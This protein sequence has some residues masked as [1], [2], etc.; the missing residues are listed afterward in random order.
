MKYQGDQNTGD[1]AR[2]V[3]Q[4]RFRGPY[5]DYGWE[6]G[7]SVLPEFRGQDVHLT[8]QERDRVI[9]WQRFQ[10][11][12]RDNWPGPYTGRG[13]R[14]YTRSDERIYEDVSELMT[15]HG[16]LDARN[17]EIEVQHGEVTLT[18]EVPDRRSKRLAED[19]ADTVPGVQDVHNRLKINEKNTPNR[20]VDRVGRSGV[21]PASEADKAPADSEAQ[22][23][24][25]WGQGERGAMG[26][27]DHGESEIHPE[28]L[29]QNK[30]KGSS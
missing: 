25:S 9:S 22:G 15:Y 7:Q 5:N 2:Q 10:G 27:N 12:G 16:Q 8:P 6:Q 19:I 23:M 24:S 28:G 11:M 26:Y 30:P 13:P 4:R 21:Y 20:W 14:N 18:G 17:I 3:P 29:K 1:W